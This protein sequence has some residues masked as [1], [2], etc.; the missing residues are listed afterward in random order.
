MRPE[1]PRASWDDED[2]SQT[3]S[4]LPKDSQSSQQD[5]NRRPNARQDTRSNRN[6]YHDQADRSSSHRYSAKETRGSNRGVRDSRSD[7]QDLREDNRGVRRYR[8]S[9]NHYRPP[10]DRPQK[11]ASDRYDNR[12]RRDNRDSR[13]N[14]DFRDNRDHRDS[15]DGRDSRDN[16]GPRDNRDARRDN[17]DQ[18]KEP[19]ESSKGL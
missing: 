15:R 2:E 10:A 6:L 19:D 13:N 1:L 12:N 17:R 14:R 16:R 5:Y 3:H 4:V 9:E 7:V 18:R 11:S 8:A